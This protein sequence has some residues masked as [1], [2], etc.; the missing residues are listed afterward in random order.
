MRI[1]RSVD[2]LELIGKKEFLAVSSSQVIFLMTSYLNVRSSVGNA[3]II[4]TL[5]KRHV[6]LCFHILVWGLLR[7]SIEKG[8]LNHYNDSLDKVAISPHA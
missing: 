1:F 7:C 8:Q 4:L 5:I 3:K 6:V 2:I